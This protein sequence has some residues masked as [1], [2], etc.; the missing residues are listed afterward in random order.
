MIDRQLLAMTVLL[1]LVASAIA[2]AV[3]GGDW[4]TVGISLPLFMT[5]SFWS[6]KLS[7]WFT[8]R[9]VPA[10]EPPI[11]PTPTEATTARPEHAQRRRRQRRR[12]GRR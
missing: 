10:P 1:S 3:S 5:A 9:V 4:V 11:A 6:L 8:R 7:R 12:R 2:L